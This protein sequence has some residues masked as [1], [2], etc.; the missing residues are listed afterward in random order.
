[1][2]C[3]RTT[4]RQHTTAR[5]ACRMARTPDRSDWPSL[6]SS[7]A[8]KMR[9]SGVCGNHQPPRVIHIDLAPLIERYGPDVKTRDVM[10][11]L[12]CAECGKAVSVSL[13]ATDLAVGGK[14]KG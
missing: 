12:K 5:L 3:Q 4:A 6:E 14:M 8:A 7:L 13:Q 10:D 11:R 2:G 9:I 1:M